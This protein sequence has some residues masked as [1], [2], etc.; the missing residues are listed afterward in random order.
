MSL[1]VT[2]LARSCN[3]ARSTVLYYESIGLLARPRR[4]AGNYRVYSEQDLDRLRQICTDLAR[5]CNVSRSTVLYYQ[6]IGLWGRPRRSAGN[7]RVYW[8]QDLDRLR[9]IC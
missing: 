4:S 7:Y 2:D 9:Q 1:T 6:Y 8:E 5:R 3:L